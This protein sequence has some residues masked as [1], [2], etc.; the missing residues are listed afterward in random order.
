MTIALCI[1]CGARKFGSVIAC[2][3]CGH[4]PASQVEAAY[5]VVLSD[6]YFDLETLDL[7]AS[8]IGR[9]GKCPS[10]PAEQEEKFLRAVAEDPIIQRVIG[11]N[12]INNEAAAAREAIPASEFEFINRLPLLIFVMVAGA[13]GKID[14]KETATFADVLRLPVC[15]RVFKS[16]LFKALVLFGDHSPENAKPRHLNSD[17]AWEVASIVR[18]HLNAQQLKSFSEDAEALALIIAGASGGFLGFGD[19]ISRSEHRAIGELRRAFKLPDMA[20]SAPSLGKFAVDWTHSFVQL[21]END[22]GLQIDRS[23]IGAY[24]VSVL[25]FSLQANAEEKVYRAQISEVV[26]SVATHVQLEANELVT[27]SQERASGYVTP[28]T[29]VLRRIAN[30]HATDGASPEI[31]MAWEFYFRAARRH[32]K[33]HMIELTTLLV[34]AMFDFVIDTEKAVRSL[35]RRRSSE[36]S[37]RTESI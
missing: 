33:G 2:D 4:A 25:D 34:P 28:T 7:I 36:L 21:L 29:D 31:Q 19:K 12:A 11:A 35:G 20:P 30:H 27:L 17:Y 5:S 14:K 15:G 23:E 9:T 8:D 26:R 22:F 10:L 3:E 16:P 6:H 24:V 13:D 32:P 1:K 37:E 18:R